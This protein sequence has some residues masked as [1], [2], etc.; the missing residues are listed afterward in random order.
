M[1]TLVLSV[2]GCVVLASS[3]ATVNQNPTPVPEA[4]AKATA[5]RGKLV[6]NFDNQVDCDASYMQCIWSPVP[7]Q[8]G[9]QCF[10]KLICG[11]DRPAEICTKELGC[12]YN[13]DKDN[14]H[15]MSQKLTSCKTGTTRE[16]CEE[17]WQCIWS[18]EGKADSSGAL[19]HCFG[20]API[21]LFGYSCGDYPKDICATTGCL[22]EETSHKCISRRF[23]TCDEFHNPGE[24][25]DHGCLWE[26]EHNTCLSTNPL[27]TKCRDFTGYGQSTCERAG[28]L[29]DPLA[30]P[31]V[32]A[33]KYQ[34]CS[35]YEPLLDSC[36]VSFGCRISAD[37]LRCESTNC[38]FN[39]SEADC[40]AQPG[41]RYN[42]S[43]HNCTNP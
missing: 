19:Q 28:C 8:N 37:H 35:A 40:N 15:C 41:C 13:N 27:T 31:P 12:V 10:S 36:P 29:W 42:K 20:T 30:H 22:W 18:P 3:C 39:Y 32:C 6:C 1:R 2:I 24:C 9:K 16:V 38:N 33:S 43:F 4:R 25:A 34:A 7:N 21:P 23:S 14:P 5:P 26:A 11:S 17:L